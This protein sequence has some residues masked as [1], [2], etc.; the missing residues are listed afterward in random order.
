MSVPHPQTSSPKSGSWI[1]PV[2]WSMAFV[3]ALVTAGVVNET[4]REILLQGVA[5]LFTFFSTPFVL[6]ASVAFVGLC[7]V[8]IVNSRRIAR[9]G[10]GWVMM[11]VKKPGDTATNSQ[12]KQAD[13]D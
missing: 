7:I 6:E 10:D 11:E 2:L 8:F 1:E 13:A 4:A 5:Y 3:A 12:E 9:E